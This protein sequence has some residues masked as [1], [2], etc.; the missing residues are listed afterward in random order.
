V[1]TSRCSLADLALLTTQCKT[2]SEYE[3][4]RTEWLHATVDCDTIYQGA[5]IAT[6]NRSPVVT[7]VDPEHT[8]RCE[9]NDR[10]WYERDRLNNAA[11]TAGG[12]A[13]DIIA[14]SSKERRESP[15]YREVMS[16]LGIQATA[17][18]VLEL[19]G[20]LVSCI[21]FGRTTRGASFNDL[22]ELRHLREALPVLA[23]GDAVHLKEPSSPPSSPTI[24]D[25][26]LTAR[27][28]EIA[29][30]ITRGLTN[31][32]I[33]SLLGTSRAT[34]KNQVATILRKS[35]VAN[36]TELAWRAKAM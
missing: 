4:A 3:R 14:L 22:T 34:V 30:Y 29:R 6:R 17:V 36:R 2:T 21:W 19:R 1:A 16:A 33:A 35:G 12:V 25:L 9:A 32:E 10:Y 18:A 26:G 28:D 13:I 20:E 11:R 7:N 5:V 31:A 8:K 27:E 24:I 23:L 15:F